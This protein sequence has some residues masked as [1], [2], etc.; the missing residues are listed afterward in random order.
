MGKV[1]FKLQKEL[2]CYLIIILP[3][4]SIIHLKVVFNIC[5]FSSPG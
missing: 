1:V 4:I 5:A 2:L 3:Y